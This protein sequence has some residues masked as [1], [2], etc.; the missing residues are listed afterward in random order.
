MYGDPYGCKDTKKSLYCR[1]S[2]ISISVKNVILKLKAILNIEIVP[3]TN[4]ATGSKNCTLG[5]CPMSLPLPWV[6]TVHL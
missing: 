3:V 1:V 4:E 2:I 6:H 5:H